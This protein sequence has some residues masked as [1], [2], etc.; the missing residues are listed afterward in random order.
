[1][2][3]GF[4]HWMALESAMQGDQPKR[5]FTRAT[6]QRVWGFARPHRRALAAFLG[7]SVVAAVL[8]VAGC[9]A[10][11]SVPALT[12][13]DIPKVKDAG[14]FPENVYRIEPN[15]TLSIKYPFHPEMNQ[16]AIVE[17]DGKIM[18]TR[19]GRVTVAGLTTVEL[20]TLLKEKTSD[21][22]RDPEVVVTIQK[23]SDK[24]IFVGGEVGKPGTIPYVKGMTPL[25]AVITAGGF[26][27]TGRLDSVILVRGTDSEA[28]YIARTLNMEQT[29]GE[30]TREP[31]FLAPHDIIFV[32]RT[33]IANA[34]LWVKQHIVDLLP[35]RLAPPG[36]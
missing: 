6:L 19:I 28:R 20:E 26:L 7:L 31:L 3:M 23:F 16:D 36:F 18:A 11:I 1:M 25:Q 5:T 4:G 15:D 12:A 35:F 34:N 30:G 17:P 21:R 13:E 14:N 24:T 8:A 10:T 9:G 29:I 27:A 22:L 32:P 33:R 2:D